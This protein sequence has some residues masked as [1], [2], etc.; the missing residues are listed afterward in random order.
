MRLPKVADLICVSLIQVKCTVQ[1]I[2]DLNLRGQKKNH[3]RTGCVQMLSSGPEDCGSLRRAE[4]RV[5]DPKLVPRVCVYPHPP[6]PT[7]ES[8]ASGP[9]TEERVGG[10]IETKARRLEGRG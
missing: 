4:G 9:G 3:Q 10:T 2:N 5:S 1:V 8:E 6:P 7:L